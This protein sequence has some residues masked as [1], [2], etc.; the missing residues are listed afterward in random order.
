MTDDDHQA[1]VVAVANHKGGVG[2]TTTTVNLAAGL[3]AAGL[4]TLVVDADA[5]ANSTWFLLG[6]PDDVEFDLRSV[7][8]GEVTA[9]EAVRP[10]HVEGVSVLPS[11]LSMAMLD[12]ALVA[13]TRREDRVRRALE[14]ILGSY[15]VILLDLPPNLG[16]TVISALGAAD[17]ILVP[18]EATVW[19]VRGVGMLMDWTAQ[20][21]EERATEATFL[22]VVLCKV[23]TQTTIFAQ[24]AAEFD[25]T[26]KDLRFRTVIPK[27]T[28]V[29]RMVGEF[30]PYTDPRSEM[31]IQVTFQAFVAEVI[32]RLHKPPKG[33]RALSV[34]ERVGVNQ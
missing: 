20:L 23:Q 34:R 19:G 24:A 9:A 4:R 10:S 33:G 25:R 16:L 8:E 32:E 17:H 12:T 29:E 30:M 2:K 18:T 11:S 6:G 5:Q 7:I 21:R 14:P 15:D 27:R 13:L 28:S 22:G 31:A 1:V 3:G 26:D